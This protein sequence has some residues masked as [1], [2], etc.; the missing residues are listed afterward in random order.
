MQSEKKNESADVSIQLKAFPVPGCVAAD[1]PQHFNAYTPDEDQTKRNRTRKRQKQCSTRVEV[2]NKYK[3]DVEEVWSSSKREIQTWFNPNLIIDCKIIDDFNL[4]T[5]FVKTGPGKYQYN[6]TDP[7]SEST[8]RF[9]PCAYRIPFLSE[10]GFYDTHMTVSHL[11][12][13]NLCYNW[14]HHV[15]EPLAV[16]K[17]RNGCPGGPSCRHKIKCIIPGEFSE[18]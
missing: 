3:T 7:E 13:N 17:G 1:Y 18:M 6:F 12:H 9:R 4:P 14:N 2:I 8:R 11:C 15:L 5:G 10:D 16:N